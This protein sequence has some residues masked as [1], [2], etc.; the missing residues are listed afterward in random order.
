MQKT[1]QADTE[2]V[3][4]SQQWVEANNMQGSLSRRAGAFAGFVGA[5]GIIAVVT[6]IVVATGNGLFTA[7]RLIAGVIYGENVSGLMP[8]V[9]GTG[10]HLVMG[11]VL[12]YIFAAIM[13]NIYR[14]MWM[15]AGLIYGL[16]AFAASALVI[17]PIVDPGMVDGSANYFVLLVAHVVYGFVLGIAGAT[18]GMFW[19]LPERFRAE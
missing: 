11:T 18:H 1:V 8:V 13:P 10:I 2:Q 12:G 19:E 3:K 6:I 5:I 16:I 17:L 14:I 9:V 7:P 15:V 4:T